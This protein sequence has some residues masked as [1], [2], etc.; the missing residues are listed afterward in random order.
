MSRSQALA[1]RAVFRNWD[2][3]A[4]SR[5]YLEVHARRYAVLLEALAPHLS[6][7]RDRSPEAAVRIL[8][9]GPG[10]QTELLRRRF[11]GAYVSTLG[12]EDTR[13][14]PRTGEVHYPLDLNTAQEPGRCPA[15]PD[16]DVVILAEVLEHLYTSPVLVLRFL[17][18]ALA[19]G[20]LLVIQTPNACAL[21]RRVKMLLGRNP[22]EPI[23]ESR[24]NP[25]HFHEYTVAELCR[26]AGDSGFAVE[27]LRLANYFDGGS[28][29]HAAFN[30][31][32]ALLPPRLREGITLVLRKASK[33]S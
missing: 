28:W 1:L 14:T 2:L 31:L 9:V 4:E 10:Y 11:P 25:G 23:R 19:D 22:M 32:S 6:A 7:I 29:K 13:L 20:G 5:A 33:A 17:R 18:S 3:D 15:L 16:H 12:F 24:T 8:D 26:A 27:D 21:N 30:R